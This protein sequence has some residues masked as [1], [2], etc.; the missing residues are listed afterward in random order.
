METIILLENLGLVFFFAFIPAL[1]SGLLNRFLI[2][3]FFGIERYRHIMREIREFDRQLL[4]AARSKDSSKLEKL[5]SR[6]PYIDRMRAQ[7]FRVTMINTIVMLG[8]YYVFFL[9]IFV[10]VFREPINISFPLFSPNFSIPLYY[11]YIILILFLS[12]IIN[13]IL[14]IYQ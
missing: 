7:T 1:L 10:A 5:Q 9:Y 3:K 11:W 2:S 4:Q 8:F 14:K 12:L 13:R 6:K